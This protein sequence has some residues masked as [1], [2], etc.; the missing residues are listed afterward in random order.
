MAEREGF[1][2]PVPQAVQQISSRATGEGPKLSKLENSMLSSSQRLPIHPLQTSSNV[3]QAKLRHKSVTAISAEKR[4]YCLPAVAS[5]FSSALRSGATSFRMMS[6][7]MSL[8]MP[9]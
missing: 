3:V 6:Q 4:I 2:P 7:M 8:S 5:S 9:R 1:E